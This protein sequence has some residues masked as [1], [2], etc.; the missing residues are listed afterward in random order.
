MI[1]HGLL[2]LII[3]MQRK[4]QFVFLN[5][6]P[7]IEGNCIFAVNHSCKWDFQYMVE[8]APKHFY[9]LAGKQRLNFIDRI[10]FIWN[11][12]VWV[13]RKN[14]GSKAKSKKKLDTLL[15]RGK[16]V[17]IFPEGTWNLTPA[18]PLL[19]MHWGIIELAQKN[20]VPIVPICLEYSDEKCFV[21]YGKSMCV[22]SDTDKGEAITKLRDTLATLRWEMWE[23]HPQEKRADIEADYWEQYIASRLQ[24]YKKL[25]Y[26]YEM[27]CVRK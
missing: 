17:C 6:C 2:K 27:S 18:E 21:K 9:V 16:C 25:D 13:D 7:T 5:S 10:G 20:H 4:H 15:R 23:L 22:D 14:K 19:P 3:S 24:E 26:E 8:L 11:G 1:L 12:T